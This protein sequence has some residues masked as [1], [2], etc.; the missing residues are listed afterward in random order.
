MA[1]FKV[2]KGKW[3]QI[4]VGNDKG[5]YHKVISDNVSICNITTRNENEAKANAKLIASAPEM[6]EML[7]SLEPHLRLNSQEE[8]NK[9]K[10]AKQLIS[11]ITE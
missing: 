4:N 10:S 11:K 9:W 7:I 8:I 6:L 2:T 1:N 3:E 5:D